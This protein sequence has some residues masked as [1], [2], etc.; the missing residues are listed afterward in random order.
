M[1]TIID[2]AT[3]LSQ[4]IIDIR[5]ELHRYPEISFKEYRTTEFITKLLV[6]ADIEIVPWGG[7][8]GVVGLLKGTKPGPVV[9]LRA[10][11]DALPVEEENECSYRSL[12]PGVMHACGHDSH[13]ASLLGAALILAELRESLAGTVKFI[14]QPAEE[15]NAGAKAM[16]EQG[17]LSNPTVDIIFGLHNTPSIP[18]G[19]VGCKEGPLMAAVDTT[20]LTIKGIG[21]HGAIPHKTKDPIMA[22]A[23]VIQGL[24]TIVSRQVDPLS[25]AV[26]SFGT[27][28][29]GHANNVIPEKVELTGT[30]RTFDPALRAEMPDKMSKVINGIAQAMDT[31]ADF[32]YRKDLP[33]VFN[34]PELTKWCREVLE[35]VFGDGVIVPTPGMGGEDFAI[36]Q[37]KVPGVFLWLGVG[38]T[39]KG[40]VHQ[41]HNPRFDID[42][43]ALKYG[44]AALAQ[45]AHTYLENKKI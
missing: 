2:R 32:V 14:F 26:I 17:V 30:V 28:K 7:D 9:A 38:N 27:I 15:I 18:A 4:R 23:A 31:E 6:Q 11:I 40:I 41:W 16:I 21:G 22:A 42:E 43:E 39:A 45:L 12:H 5:R 24:Q 44:A 33:A 36:F 1:K 10:D 25:S 19:Q 34:P 13:T 29:G 35:Q 3:E 20:F 37:E 8:T